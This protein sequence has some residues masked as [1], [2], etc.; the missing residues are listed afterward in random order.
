MGEASIVLSIKA[1]RRRN[2][3]QELTKHHGANSGHKASVGLI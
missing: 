1:V 2:T 3:L